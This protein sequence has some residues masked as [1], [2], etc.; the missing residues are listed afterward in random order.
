MA[1]SPRPIVY[2]IIKRKARTFFKIIKLFLPGKLPITENLNLRT[3][4]GRAYGARV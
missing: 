3:R 2:Q 1:F 4:S